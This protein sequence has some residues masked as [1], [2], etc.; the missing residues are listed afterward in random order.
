MTFNHYW[1]HIS[2]EKN[3]D[4]HGAILEVIHFLCSKSQY[5]LMDLYQIML[6]DLVH[7]K[8]RYIEFANEQKN[9]MHHLFDE[10]L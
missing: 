7:N 9:K 3:E 10:N 5:E 8:E 2:I 1:P 4:Q 6:P